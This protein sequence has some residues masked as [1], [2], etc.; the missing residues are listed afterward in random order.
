MVKTRLKQDDLNMFDW[1]MT[2]RDQGNFDTKM[3]VFLHFKEEVTP[4]VSEKALN[5]MQ[6]D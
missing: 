5:D 3:V 2:D 1:D 6:Q 4:M